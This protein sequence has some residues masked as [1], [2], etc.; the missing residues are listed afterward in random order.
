[1][2]TPPYI[3]FNTFKTLL[4]WLEKEG[5]PLR[6][7][8]SFENLNFIINK[9]STDRIFVHIFLTFIYRI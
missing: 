6:I 4:Y 9:I 2:E 7:D 8:R 5:V 1:M 3:S